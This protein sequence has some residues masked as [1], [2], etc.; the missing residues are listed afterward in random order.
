MGDHSAEIEIGDLVGDEF[1]ELV[2][3]AI[4]EMVNGD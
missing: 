3:A 1:V 2:F 4:E